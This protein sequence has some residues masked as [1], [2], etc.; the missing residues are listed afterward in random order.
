MPFNI[1]WVGLL[2]GLALL[3]AVPLVRGEV[4]RTGEPASAPAPEQRALVPPAEQELRTQCWQH[5]VKIIDQV[6]L[7]GLALTELVKQQAVTFSGESGERPRTLILP[8][9]D[10]MCL[11][12]PV[13]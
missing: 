12:E 2:A 5:G 13:R 10:A 11:I 1:K 9:A 7:R 4:S 6:G 3:A 8:F